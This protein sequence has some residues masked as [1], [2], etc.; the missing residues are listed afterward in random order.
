MTVAN[1]IGVEHRRA[2][3][4]PGGYRRRMRRAHDPARLRG[5]RCRVRPHPQQQR[6][7]AGGLRGQRQLAAGD[8]VE[9]ARFAKG[10][11]HHR[12][13]RIA[14]E[15]I[16]GGAQCGLDIGGAYGDEQARIEAELGKPARR[17]RAGFNFGKIL[18]HPDQRFSPRKPARDARDKTGRR[19]ALV[20]F[21]K[22]LMHGGKRQPAA[23]HDIG[24]PVAKRDPVQPVHIARRL[25]ALD[26]AA[27][28]RKRAH[29]CGG[30]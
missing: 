1:E 3:R 17:Q 13:Q 18:P 19:R 16:G 23:Q 29:A 2:P 5:G 30:A 15:R 27:Q 28:G 8:E 11:Q 21:G 14:G 10:L 20:S 26:A 12:A 9:L 22:H 6:G 4:T 24:A 7:D 25:D